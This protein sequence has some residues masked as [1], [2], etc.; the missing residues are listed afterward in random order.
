M[1][2]K[3]PMIWVGWKPHSG[4]GVEWEHERRNRL[5]S[6]VQLAA[7]AEGNVACYEFWVLVSGRGSG[8]GRRRRA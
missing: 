8:G 5:K 7:L 6:A 3:A 2:P 4:A 1:P